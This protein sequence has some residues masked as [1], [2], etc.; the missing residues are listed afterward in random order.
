MR[1]YCSYMGAAWLLSRTGKEISVLNHPSETF[2]FES[3]VD[4]INEYGSASEKKLASEYMKFPNDRLKSK[5]LS[6]Y[7][8]NW[9]K[10]R[11]WGTFQEEVTFRITSTNFNWYRI[12]VDF[13]L[14]HPNFRRSSITVES[15]KSSGVRKTYWSNVDYESAVDSANEAILSTQLLPDDTW[16]FI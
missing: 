7:N 6:I 5:L 15:D 1:I 9:C 3:V 11:T 16:I 8:S 4:I 13:L 2:E 14:N 12:I 10:V